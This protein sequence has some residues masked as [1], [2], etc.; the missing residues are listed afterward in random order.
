MINLPQLAVSGMSSRTLAFFLI[1]LSKNLIY[2]YRTTPDVKHP[3]RLEKVIALLELE[4]L[5]V[6]YPARLSMGEKQR[7]AIGR[8]L[9][10]QPSLLLMDEPLASLDAQHKIQI[11]P[12]LK[13]VCNELETP[14]L[15]VSH[16]IDE[17][18]HLAHYMAFITDGRCTAH[19]P[20]IEVLARHDV[21]KFSGI[22]GSWFYFGN[23][24]F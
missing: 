20:L 23:K 15:Y 9:L 24:R 7:V 22:G 13:R 21:Q 1:S 11:V 14:I 12:F 18:M 8:A 2:G 4:D 16:L 10:R 17:I 3:L 19:G 5:L 6:R